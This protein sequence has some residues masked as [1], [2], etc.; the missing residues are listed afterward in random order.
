MVAHTKNGPNWLIPALLLI[1]VAGGAYW[2]FGR[3][4]EEAQADMPPPEVAVQTITLQTA[5]TSEEYPGRTS[6]YEVSQVRPQVDGVILKRLFTEGSRV[7]KGQQLYQIDPAPYQAAYDSAKATLV[8]ADAMVRSTQA[9]L[10]R[11]QTL[12]KVE[13]VSRQEY[14][15][16]Q[17]SF[18]QAQADVGIAKAALAQAKINL[19]YTKVYAPIDGRIGKSSVTPGALVSARQAEALAVITQLHPMY[20][21]I[22]QASEDMQRLRQGLKNKA[23]QPVSLSYQNG[24]AY[25]EKGTLQFTDITVD[26]TTSSVQLRALFPNPE[27]ELLPG[28][29]VRAKLE[30]RA[31]NAILVPQKATIRQPDASLAVWVVQPDDTVQ[32][33]TITTVRAVDDQW[34]VASGLKEGD[35]IVVEGTQKVQPGAKVSIAQPAQ[36]KTAPATEAAPEK[37]A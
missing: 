8:K 26:P 22:T 5:D 28:M 17:A 31:E 24:L 23:D 29:F 33:A 32:P 7:N 14:D 19:D 1:V 9:R 30:M 37:G 6:A 16:T 3:A 20:V 18:A 25:A 10:K 2:F 34:L 35:R 4:G 21:D 11:Y 12:V 15:D 27:G 13:A 36:E